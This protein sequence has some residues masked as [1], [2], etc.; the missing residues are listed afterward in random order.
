[1]R[2]NL[3][4]ILEIAWKNVWRSKYRSLVV[5]VAITLGLW[6]A[7]FML[8]FSWGMYDQ[9]INQAIQNEISHIQIHDSLYVDEPKVSY[10][11]ANSPEIMAALA[12]DA[13]V[14]GFSAR[15]IV[16]GMLASSRTS[17]GIK[18]VGVDKEAEDQVTEL[19]AKLVDGDYFE[20]DRRNQIIIGQKLADKLQVKV[21]SKLVLTFQDPEGEIVAGAFRVVGLYKTTNPKYD[22][23]NAFLQ[24]HDIT[25]LL[26]DSSAIHEIAVLLKNNEVQDAALERYRARYPELAV[27]GW[28]D[29]APELGFAIDSFDQIM[30][31]FM[32]IIMLALAFGIINTMLMA[33]LERV[34]E[35]GMLMA[36]GM[37][38]PRIFFMIMFETVFLALVGGPLGVLLGYLSVTY[39]GTHGIDLGAWAEGF[40]SIG[41]DSMVYT[42][43]EGG[44][45]LQ[46]AIQVIVV[47]VLAAIYPA[48]KA[49]K[50]DPVTAIRKL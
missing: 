50:L 3:R 17:T 14:A 20:G 1:M 48:I 38:R 11:L 21:R 19:S 15:T 41:F 35:I 16:S 9:R 34:R 45:Y 22:E 37:N 2:D 12:Q 47:A 4:M 25:R 30:Q 8:A 24:Q 5:I 27:Q 42:R 7:I 10:T 43:L 40:G 18:A 49:L 31:I 32:G 39:F 36:I 44:R 6:A 28:R 23:A 29:V 33:V 13:D 26:G 46:V